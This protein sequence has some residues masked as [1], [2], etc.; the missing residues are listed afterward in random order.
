MFQ[1]VG[2]TLDH[3]RARTGQSQAS[4]ARAASVGKSQ[5]S[6]YIQGKEL[7]K[8]ESL[9]RILA[10]LGLGFF[11]FFWTLHLFDRGVSSKPILRRSDIEESFTRLTR[12][13]FALHG[14]I[15]D[16]LSLDSF[17]PKKEYDDDETD[18]PLRES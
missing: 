16:Q 3:L 6:K 8:L 18:G 11:E 2:R 17:P 7:P 10:A 15:L 5:L 4:L 9:E 12:D 13:L 1:N 14:A